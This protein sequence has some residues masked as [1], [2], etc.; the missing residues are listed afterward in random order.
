MRI[1]SIFLIK[2]GL[3]WC[4]KVPFYISQ[5]VATVIF[6]QFK[7]LLKSS[8]NSNVLESILF[9][10]CYIYISLPHDLI[11]TKLL[12]LVTGVLTDSQK[13]TSLLQTSWDTF[14]TRNNTY[15][16]GACTELCEAFTFLVECIKRLLLTSLGTSLLPCIHHFKSNLIFDMDHMRIYV[17]FYDRVFQ[18]TVPIGTNCAPSIAGW[19]LYCY[20]KD[21]MSNLHKSKKLRLCWYASLYFSIA[22]W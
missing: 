2:S 20:E 5:I 14:P 10:F 15:K 1:W 6:G 12:S 22:L 7:S 18:Q 9:W 13:Y 16:C 8:K 19:F 11:K 3:K 17:Q 21:Y 4:I